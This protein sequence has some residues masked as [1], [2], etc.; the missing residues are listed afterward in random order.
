MKIHLYWL[1]GCVPCKNMKKEILKLSKYFNVV[2]IENSHI[3]EEIKSKYKLKMYPTLVF[4]TNTNRFLKKL[5][6]FHKSA[7]ILKVYDEALRL[8][9]LF[10]KKNNDKDE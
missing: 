3:A 2:E 10:R 4:L 9:H 1:E 6:G 5:D 7:D 8:E